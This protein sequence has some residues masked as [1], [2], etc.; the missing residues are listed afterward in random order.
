MWMSR[1]PSKDTGIAESSLPDE[2]AA[3]VMAYIPSSW[4][5]PLVWGQMEERQ[6]QACRGSQVLGGLVQYFPGVSSEA[7]SFH[8]PREKVTGWECMRAAVCKPL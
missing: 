4:A 3:W 7:L 6:E 1:W 2:G 8:P 5:L